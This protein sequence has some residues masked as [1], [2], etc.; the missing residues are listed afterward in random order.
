MG[1]PSIRSL[2][3]VVAV[4]SAAACSGGV[5][6]PDSREAIGSAQAA[7]TVCGQTQV[8]GMDVSH[9]DGAIDWQTAKGAGIAFAIAKATESTTYVDPTF[10]TN[11]ADMK[12][13]G[14][15]RAAY[16]FFRANVDPIQQANHVM[17]VV[18]TLEAGD[19]PI[20][21]DL[22]TT[23]GETGATIAANALAFLDAVTKGTGKKAIVYTSPGFM[24]GLS[25]TAG[26]ANYTL[27]VANWGVSCPN[28]PSPWTQW[29]FWQDTDKGTVNGVPSTAVD[30]DVFNGTLAE[31]QGFGGGVADGGA[32]H[33]GG[34]AHEAGSKGDAG[35][36]KDGGVGGEPPL[37]GSDNNPSGGD[38]GGAPS[39]GSGGGGGA[40]NGVDAVPT[41][42][43]GGCA[44]AR[45]ASSTG[46]GVACVVA[47]SA[48]LAVTRRRRARARRPRSNA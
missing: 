29:A 14:I 10:A 9:Y 31:L 47:A 42:S 39:P 20:V 1:T 43:S 45:G 12:A 34:V 11:W 30:L 17:Q 33:D 37:D 22:E 26:F 35:G 4:S 8:K 7:A 27:W 16:H 36:S 21:L 13:N 28:V 38:S 24:G 18:G 41:A 19:L 40:P 3:A 44:I 46:V 32:S 5:D 6:S 48:L 23:D 25:G 2:V 15:V